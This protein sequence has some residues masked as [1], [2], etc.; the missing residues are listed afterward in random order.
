MRITGNLV[1]FGAYKSD[2]SKHLEEAVNSTP[3]YKRDDL[4]DI[5]FKSIYDGKMNGKNCIGIG[6]F[7]SVYQIDDVYVMRVPKN[8]VDCSPRAYLGKL[9]RLEN[10]I[11]KQ[12]AKRLS[13]YY[14][15]KVA[16]F[17]NIAILKNV[18]GDKKHVSAGIPAYLVGYEDRYKYFSNTYLPEFASLPQQAYDNI[19]HDLK[20]LNEY[21]NKY[22]QCYSY[23][24]L[25]PNNFIKVEDEI[26]VV[27]DI[28]NGSIT[29]QPENNL[30]SML[31][32]F[33]SPQLGI[34]P[35]TL[36]KEDLNNIYTIFEK[37]VLAAEK[38]ELNWGNL[39]F[40][41]PEYKEILK[42]YKIPL[43]MIEVYYDVHNKPVND[44]ENYFDIMLFNK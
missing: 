16:K 15:N 14:G 23:D 22:G 6:S 36:S 11:E 13:I 20:V 31:V 40:L 19:A 1:S 7:N 33:L 37:C 3:D 26:R 28:D 21:K 25:N 43:D 17:G 38:T 27:D 18:F 8:P 5:E 12:I 30:L 32:A 4:L 35:N 41:Q 34:L 2:F 9:N 29:F 42:T 10:D 24:V 44:I 39:E